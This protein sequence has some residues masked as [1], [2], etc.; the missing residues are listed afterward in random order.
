MSAVITDPL[1][2]ELLRIIEHRIDNH[3]RS[4]QKRIGPSEIGT[5]CPRALIHKLAGEDEPTG[6]DKWR[7]TVGTAIHSWFEDTIDGQRTDW[8]SETPVSIGYIDDIEITGS[9]DLLACWD[10][11]PDVVDLKTAS[12]TKLQTVARHGMPHITRV[13]VN[14]YGRGWQRRGITPKRVGALYVPRDGSL[15]EA[16]LVMEP[17]NE[18]VAVAALDRCTALLGFLRTYELEAALGLYELCADDY[19]DWCR[20]DQARRPRTPGIAQAIA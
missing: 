3:P 6:R 20:R 17:Y 8:H 11:G 5:E 12:K 16:M 9:C 15:R 18:A 14:A 10:E 13:Q 19:C 4:L 2:L 1:G 7:A